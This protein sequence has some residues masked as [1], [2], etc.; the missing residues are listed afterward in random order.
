[1]KSSYRQTFLVILFKVYTAHRHLLFGSA[2]MYLENIMPFIV[3]CIIHGATDK[4][5]YT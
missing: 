2:G 5:I 3:D 4:K 1:M